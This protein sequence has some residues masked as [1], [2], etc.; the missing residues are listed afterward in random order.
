MLN[1]MGF[2]LLIKMERISGRVWLGRRFTAG[3]RSGKCLRDEIT[4]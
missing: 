2:R 3:L 4:G 1:L